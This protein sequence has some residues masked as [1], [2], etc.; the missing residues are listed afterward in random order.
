MKFNIRTTIIA[1]IIFLIAINIYLCVQSLFL[2]ETILKLEEDIQKL[3]LENSQLEKK[4]F[5]LNS[6]ESLEKKAQSLGFT[7][8]AEPIYL[9]NLKYALR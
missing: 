8:K 4:V 7:K 5:F 6:V 2:G 3:I 9:E 1:L